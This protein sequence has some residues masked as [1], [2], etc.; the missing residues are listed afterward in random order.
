VCVCVC[1]CVCVRARVR[2]WWGKMMNP[3][4][5]AIHVDQALK[6]RESLSSLGLT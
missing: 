1:V 6:Q 5:P 2:A 4:A 3:V